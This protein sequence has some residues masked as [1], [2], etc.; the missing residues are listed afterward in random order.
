MTGNPEVFIEYKPPI[1]DVLFGDSLSLIGSREGCILTLVSPH[2]LIASLIFI[3][4]VVR[5]AP[6]STPSPRKTYT[7]LLLTML[8]VGRLASIFALTRLHKKER[9]REEV[10]C[11]RRVEI[12]GLNGVS[13]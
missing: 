2:M 6:P 12:K 8:D 5:A 3:I 1:K 13:I 9:K 7:S 10:R 4:Q 11:A